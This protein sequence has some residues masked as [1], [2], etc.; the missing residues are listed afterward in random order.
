M[1]TSSSE[2]EFYKNVLGLNGT[3]KF[4]GAMKTER[5]WHLIAASMMTWR[6]GDILRWYPSC[7]STANGMITG[8]QSKKPE[9]NDPD[10]GNKR[11]KWVFQL[12]IRDYFI[13]LV[14]AS[15]RSGK[16]EEKFLIVIIRI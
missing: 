2:H 7:K 6:E 10:F 5:C 8:Y 13:K 9:E 11:R 1:R 16:I 14:V 4:K 15:R 12:D 3:E